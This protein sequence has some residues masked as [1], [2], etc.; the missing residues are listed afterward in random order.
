VSV[1]ARSRAP[2]P[3][4]EIASEHPVVRAAAAVP[5]VREIRRELGPVY[6]LDQE[7]GA[8]PGNGFGFGRSRRDGTPKLSHIALKFRLPPNG[9]QVDVQTSIPSRALPVWMHVLSVI[10]AASHAR[11]AFRCRCTW[12]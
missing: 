5:S 1:S 10:D 11:R 7:I 2:G 3:L 9:E 6:G 4:D 8:M 12:P